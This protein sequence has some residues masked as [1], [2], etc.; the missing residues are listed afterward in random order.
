MSKTK[1]VKKSLIEEQFDRFQ[2][3]PI[4]KLV[5]ADWN[6]KEDDEHNAAVL[7]NAIKKRGQILNSV[8]RELET[9]YYE[10]ADGNHRLVVMKR[11]GMKHMV[12]YNAGKISVEEAQRIA[13][14]LNETRFPSNDALLGRIFRGWDGVYDRKDILDTMPLSEKDYDHLK[15]ISEY[16]PATYEAQEVG[17]DDED[18]SSEYKVLRVV[19]DA[20]LHKQWKSLEKKFS[21]DKL[22]E[23]KVALIMFDIFMR[24]GLNSKALM[25]ELEATLKQAGKE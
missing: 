25:K 18:D 9:G 19:V 15:A 16:E 13:V 22:P 10:V 8:V 11:L 21:T 4:E 2:L 7:E 3:I 12:C 20:E 6:Y 23:G 24:A 5:P 14:E 1:T 17:E